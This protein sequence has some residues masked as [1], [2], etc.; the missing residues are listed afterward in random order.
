M[1]WIIGYENLYKINKQG[2]IWSCWYQ[3]IMAPQTS[4]DGYLWVYL[5]KEGCR[6]KCYIHRLI[7]LQYIENPEGLPQVDHID[8]NKLNNNLENLRW[9]T[10]HT[11]RL[12]R[13]DLICLLT[14]EQK[15]ERHTKMKA[16]KLKWYHEH[17]KPLIG[18]A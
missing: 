13:T 18:F 4:Q 17:K 10:Q 6:R 9:V 11:N 7:A 12:N 8:R 2:E 16:Y 1:D 3:K 5:K 15:Q 14:E